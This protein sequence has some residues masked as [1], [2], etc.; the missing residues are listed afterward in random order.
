MDYCEKEGIKQSMSRKG[1]PYDNAV[2]ESFFG[3]F[4]AEKINNYVMKDCNTVR[5]LSMDYVHMYYNSRR[6]HSSL[7]GM[8]PLEKRYAA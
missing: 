4:K 8:T 5:D 7:N 6:P 1:T 2:M 3:K